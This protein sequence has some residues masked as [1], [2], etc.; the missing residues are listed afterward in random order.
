MNA[1][2]G[3]KSDFKDIILENIADGVFSVNCDWRITYYNR[4]AEKI[5]GIC[6]EKALGK[7][8]WEVF[9]SEIC[10]TACLMRQTIESGKAMMNKSFNI[11]HENGSRIPISVCTAVLRD[12]RGNVI[13]GVETFRDLTIVEELRKELHQQYSFSDIIAHS[14][15]MQKLFSI[16]PQIAESGSTV[17]IEGASGTGKELFSRAI[18]N[19]SPRK[20]KPFVAV[21]CC[22]LPDTLLESELFGYKA[23]AFTDAKRDKPGRFAMA[24]GG[25]IFLDE[26]GEMSKALQIRLLRVLQEKTFEPL[27][28]TKKFKC[29]V[30]VIA[31]TNKS[32]E[33]EMKEGQFRQDLYYRVNVIRLSLPPLKERK[34]DIPLLTDHF[35]TRFNRLRGKEILGIS[36]EPLCAFMQHDWPGNVRELENAIEHAFILCSEGYIQLAH[37]PDTFQ[38]KEENAHVPGGLTLG[39]I[40]ARAIHAALKRNNGKRMATAR[41]LGISKN[42]LRRKLKNMGIQSR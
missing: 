11:I 34:E 12:K 6:R 4:A 39:E 41:E 19:L 35:I 7:L 14:N 24:E 1:L 27:G 36:D 37:L 22:A 31:A 29:D 30:R 5:T 10:E 33:K 2:V 40:E 3:T 23:G 15:K 16:L 32:L 26:I 18:H 38:P 17:L 13:G 42:T 20:N 25:T 21:N 8:C 9:H 28:S